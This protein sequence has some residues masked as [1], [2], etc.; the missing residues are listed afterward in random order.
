MVNGTL[1]NHHSS[2]LHD[3]AC[4]Q[5]RPPAGYRE[6]IVTLRLRRILRSHPR[7]SLPASLRFLLPPRSLPRNPPSAHSNPSSASSLPLLPFIPHIPRPP[8]LPKITPSHRCTLPHSPSFPIVNQSRMRQSVLSVW[9]HLALV[10]GSQERSRT[11]SQNVVTLC[12]RYDTKSNHFA[13][14]LTTLRL[15]LPPY[16]DPLPIKDALRFPERLTL[17]FVASVGAP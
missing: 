1:R 9:S 12:T 10:S 3:L 14:L 8:A 5:F 4:D 7:T 2:S 17:A 16:M 6:P 13:H 15:A 11:S